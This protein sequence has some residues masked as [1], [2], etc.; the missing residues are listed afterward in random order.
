MLGAGFPDFILFKKV[1]DWYKI[2]FIECKINGRLTQIE[3]LK[4]DWM[5]KAGHRCFVA[6]NNDGEINTREFLE[7]KG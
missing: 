7:C 4:L 3:K 2:L 6:F 5:V 1:N